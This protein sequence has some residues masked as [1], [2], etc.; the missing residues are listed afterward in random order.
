MDANIKNSDVQGASVQVKGAAASVGA[1]ASKSGAA[2]ASNAA[3]SNAAAPASNA[4]SVRKVSTKGYELKGNRFVISIKDAA[5]PSILKDIQDPPQYIY[6]IGNSEAL[7]PGVAVVGARR[8]SPYGLSCAELFARQAALRGLTIISGGAFGCDQAAH[9]AAIKAACPTIVVFGGGADVVYP[10]R[11]FGLFQK[12][13]D[14]GGAIISEHAWQTPPL[15]AFFVQRNRIIAGLS[16]LLLIVEAGLP[17]GTF[18][19]ADF[20]LKSGREVCAVPGSISSPNSRGSN[21]LIYDGAIPIIDEE[22]FDSALDAAFT[23][24]PLIMQEP[25]AHT[26]D[27]AQAIV[28]SNPKDKLIAA[29]AAQPMSAEEL[30]DSFSESTPK[31]LATLSQLELQGAVQRG[32]DGRYQVCPRYRGS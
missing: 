4:V 7:R 24:E 22:T 10:K 28:N 30:A 20:A 3:S 26:Q 13:I 31:L 19:T 18:T 32:Y 16:R 12:I 6:G 8:A 21:Q 2:P 9:S 29:L 11:G 1:A 27:L 23:G 15:P 5:Y 25:N 14:S 17:S